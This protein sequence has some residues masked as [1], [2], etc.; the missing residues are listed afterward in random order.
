MLAFDLYPE[1]E[2]MT[3]TFILVYSKADNKWGEILF[4]LVKYSILEAFSLVVEQ[5]AR[6]LESLYLGR[7]PQIRLPKE[8]VMFDAERLYQT[9]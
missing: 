5:D 2:T 3:R 6:V 1:S 9:W 8:E 7:K 4:P